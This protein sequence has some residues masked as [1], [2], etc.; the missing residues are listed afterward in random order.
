[1]LRHHIRPDIQIVDLVWIDSAAFGLWKSAEANIAN[2]LADA[3]ESYVLVRD[4]A[5]FADILAER[6]LADV[7]VVAISGPARL[8]KR[9]ALV[10][11]LALRALVAGRGVFYTSWLPRLCFSVLMLPIKCRLFVHD[12]NIFRS[13]V[14]DE[15]FR[16][17]SFLSR[18]H[19]YLSIRRATVVQ[20]FARSVARQLKTLRR[21]PIAVVGQTV[22]IV[23]PQAPEQRPDSAVI[24]LDDRA[25]KGTWALPRLYS[26]K[27]GFQLTVIGKI[28]PASEKLLR[29]RGI[30]VRASRPSDVEKFK[31]MAEAQVVIFASKY[32][33]FGLPPRE[34]AAV[35]APCVIARRAALLDIP[36]ALSLSIDKLGDHI[37]LAALPELAAG[38]D[39]DALARWAES[40]VGPVSTSWAPA[41]GRALRECGFG[42]VAATAKPV[43]KSAAGQAG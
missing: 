29:D 21:D 12:L 2:L 41:G 10:L 28:D 18:L 31:L 16:Q 13:R 33:G 25:Y 6:K 32:E 15:K 38:I 43:A 20:S 39:R 36:P 26:S 40:F 14:H 7:H 27:P 9:E 5:K 1:M 37:D 3:R 19:Q 23:P 22:R 24:F 8:V 30:A 35:G 11:W 34:A 42:A 17:P 4:D